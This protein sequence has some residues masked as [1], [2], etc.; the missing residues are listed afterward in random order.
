MLL[1]STICISIL[2]LMLLFNFALISS[3]PILSLNKSFSVIGLQFSFISAIESDI[4][5]DRKFLVISSFPEY[6]KIL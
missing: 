6:P 3:M 1:L 4:I 2:Q 5:E